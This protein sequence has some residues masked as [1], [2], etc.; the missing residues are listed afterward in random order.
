M[1]VVN[2][3]RSANQVPFGYEPPVAKVKGS[4]FVFETFEDWTFENMN[5]LRDWCLERKFA[6]IVLFPQHDETLRRMGISCDMPYYQRVKNLEIQLKELQEPWQVSI[7]E[8]EGKRK[9]YT[10]LDTSLHF[11]TDKYRAPHFLWMSDRY[12]NLFVTYS[13][14]KE[15]I[16]KLR[17]FISPRY[18]VPLNPKLEQDKERWE[19]I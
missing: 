10:P 19:V 14:Y 2:M 16:K 15:W 18:H 12:A 8:W 3:A 13:S 6:E 7:D 11:L 9:K 5:K 1:E 4:I 17:L